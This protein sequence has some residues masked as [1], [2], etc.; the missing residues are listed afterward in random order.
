MPTAS[1][2]LDEA[3]LYHLDLSSQPCSLESLIGW[4]WSL[5]R[6]FGNYF[7]LYL[8]MCCPPWRVHLEPYQTCGY[9][10]RMDYSM[11]SPLLDTPLAGSRFG[12]SL[13]GNASDTSC[14]STFVILI[15]RPLLVAISFSFFLGAFPKAH[16]MAS[17]SDL[18]IFQV[19]YSTSESLWVYVI[20]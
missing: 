17:P 20:W 7:Q 19:E 10:Q 12:N 1:I 11:K 15:I 5:I 6:I 8:E 18:D 4:R 16:L 9:G 2:Q 3:I 14:F 13:I